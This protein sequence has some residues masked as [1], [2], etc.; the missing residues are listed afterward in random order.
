MTTERVAVAEYKAALR[1]KLLR[2]R[3]VG[4]DVV[5][6][7]EI[8]FD[9]LRLTARLNRDFEAV[10]RPRGWTWAG[11]R[12][13]NLL[14]V[15]GSLAPGE[16]A[17]LSGASRASISSA[18]N[19]LEAGGHVTRATNASNRRHVE[20][21]LTAKGRRALKSAIGVQAQREHAWL[22]ALTTDERARLAKLIAR[23]VEQPGP[24]AR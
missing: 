8:M 7:M 3:V 12:I 9:L 1:E 17:R 23:L 11:F 14:W 24:S 2:D 16:L 6:R 15:L 18:L 5:D 13:A 22:D 10:H 21:T 19:T 20:V 4:D